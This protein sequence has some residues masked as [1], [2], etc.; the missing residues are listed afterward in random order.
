M[1]VSSFISKRLYSH[2]TKSSFSIQL[3]AHTWKIYLEGRKQYIDGIVCFFTQ[4]RNM[5]KGHEI[6]RQRFN[7]VHVLAIHCL[8]RM[9]CIDSLCCLIAKVIQL[10]MFHTSAFLI[11]SYNFSFILLPQISWFVVSL[12][13]V[14]WVIV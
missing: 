12:E 2:Q 6:A 11:S 13:Y 1:C 8:S 4:E 5:L 7:M 10:I 9:P 14:K 3:M